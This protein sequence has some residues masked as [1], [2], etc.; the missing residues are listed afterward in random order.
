MLVDAHAHLDRYDLVG[1]G[2]VDAALAEIQASRI[3]TVSNSMDPASYERNLEIAAR[4]D[5]VLPI[6]G[7]HPWNAL[8]WAD[9]LDDLRPLAER[10]PMLGEVGLDFY[11]VNNA[12]SY[13]AQRRV[14]EFFLQAAIDQDKILHLHTKGAEGEVL[15]LLDRYQVR[16]AVVHWYSGPLDALEA[17][18]ARGFYFTAGLET[19]YSDHIGAI[20]RHI[21]LD[22][23]LTETDNPGGPSDYLGGPG[24]PLLIEEVV[25]GL[26][27][28]RGVQKT[29]ILHAVQE[30]M[31]RLLEGDPWLGGTWPIARDVR[32]RAGEVGDPVSG[33]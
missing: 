2:A 12:E 25:E 10:S 7:V 29:V 11:F 20:V 17:L 4:S 14:F 13:A 30:N 8:E 31:A 16:R 18:I 26:A 9:R 19:R 1:E 32:A 28:A 24:M 23:L 15:A 27:E 22:R 3:Q 33:H 21:P 6:F 5:L